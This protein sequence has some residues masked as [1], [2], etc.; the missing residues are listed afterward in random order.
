MILPC[1]LPDKQ[2][3]ATP[4]LTAATSPDSSPDH[5]ERHFL[6][7]VFF[8]AIVENV[9]QWFEDTSSYLV[10]EHFFAN[11]RPQNFSLFL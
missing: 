5:L 7:S 2:G 1:F 4:G 3:I 11:Q 10:T 6:R 9:P 8:V